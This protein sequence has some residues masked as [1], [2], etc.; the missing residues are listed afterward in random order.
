[1][2]LWASQAPPGPHPGQCE[3]NESHYSLKATQ[4]VG[5]LSNVAHWSLASE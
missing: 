1:M 4:G 3:M 5:N 2:L